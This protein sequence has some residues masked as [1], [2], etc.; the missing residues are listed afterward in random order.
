MNFQ[1]INKMDIQGI[2]KDLINESSSEYT[3]NAMGVAKESKSL[4]EKCILLRKFTTPQSTE[5]EKIIRHDLKIDKPEN[6][7]SG[8]G[9]KNGVKYE[10]KVSLHDKEC[11]VNLRQIR[12]YHSVV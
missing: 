6:N 8:D 1:Q 3:K 12:P 11:N 9:I 4:W 5:A 2:A 7:I 10:I